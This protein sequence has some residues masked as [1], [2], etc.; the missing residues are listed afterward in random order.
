MNQTQHDNVIRLCETLEAGTYKKGTDMLKN[1]SD[2]SYCCLGVACDI[3]GLGTWEPQPGT[4]YTDYVI[5]GDGFSH[6]CGL[7][8]KVMEYYGFPF[9]SGFKGSVEYNLIDYNDGC[10]DMLAPMSHPEIAGE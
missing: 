10:F 6:T 2:N 7:P 5:E 3:S 9:S 8:R 1:N 4:N